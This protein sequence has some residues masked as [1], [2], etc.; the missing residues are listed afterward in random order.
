M[1]NLSTVVFGS[2][3]ILALIVLAL[4]GPVLLIW[5]V[6]T[7]S[8]SGGSSFYI[9]HTMFNYFVAFVLLVLVRGGCSGS[10]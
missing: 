2:G 7:L 1:K 10:K 5:S 3:L 6:N 9:N 8:E 4:L